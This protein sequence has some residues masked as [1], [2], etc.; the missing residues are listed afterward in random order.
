MSPEGAHT[1]PEGV[2]SRAGRP[3]VDRATR[4][5]KKTLR[6]HMPLRGMCMD[7]YGVHFVSKKKKKKIC[8]EG[9]AHETKGKIRRRVTIGA[10]GQ[11][12]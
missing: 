3:K 11:K 12:A 1:H 4:K 6:E 10:K 2:C 7:P 8:G 5:K 9:E